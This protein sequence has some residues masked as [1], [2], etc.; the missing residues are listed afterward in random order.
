MYKYKLRYILRVGVW[1]CDMSMH[2]LAERSKR[3]KH[4]SKVVRYV[5][6]LGKQI[7]EVPR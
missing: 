2:V 4:K 7:S 6:I 3:G 1:I 5:E